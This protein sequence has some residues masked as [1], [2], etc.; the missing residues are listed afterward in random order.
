MSKCFLCNSRFADP[1]YN[2]KNNTFTYICKKCV[3]FTIFN[4]ENK[5]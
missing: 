1:Y 4:K 3:E 5:K 2:E